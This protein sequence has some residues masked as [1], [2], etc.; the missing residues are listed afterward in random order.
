MSFDH[1]RTESSAFQQA[2]LRSERLRIL[3]VLGT[4]AVA[5]LLRTLRT[6]VVG[7]SENVSSWL[8]TFELLGLFSIYEFAMLL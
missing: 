8:I 1:L 2:L 6:V 3:I 7:G 4:I 5:L